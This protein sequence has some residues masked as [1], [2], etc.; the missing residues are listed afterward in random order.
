VGIKRALDSAIGLPNRSS[1][2]SW[3]LVLL[4]PLDVRSNLISPIFSGDIPECP[5]SVFGFAYKVSDDMR[6]TVVSSA[7]PSAILGELK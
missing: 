4:M 6:R 1:S 5:R 2:A 3:M 7:P